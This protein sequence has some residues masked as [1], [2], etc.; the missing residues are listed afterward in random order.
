MDYPLKR[1]YEELEID[2]L[3][4]S[5]Q[6]SNLKMVFRGLSNSGPPNLNSMFEQYIPAKSLRSEN[7]SLI[8][9]AKTN[10]IFTEW[11]IAY[12]GCVYWNQVPLETKQS[13]S[14]KNF[15]CKFKKYG[16]V[17]IT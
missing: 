11:D 17:A 6:K 8:L 15:K 9:L 12:R 10:L 3:A 16:T 14:I 4:V 7:Q 5:R 13:T 2:T 1:L